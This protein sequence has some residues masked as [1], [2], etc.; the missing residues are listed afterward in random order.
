MFNNAE[1]REIPQA[2]S[3]EGPAECEQPQFAPL[4]GPAP[5]LD[6]QSEDSSPIIEPLAAP[7]DCNLELVCRA[8]ADAETGGPAGYAPFAA[9]KRRPPMPG[10]IDTHAVLVRAKREK[11]ESFKV[12]S[13]QMRGARQR[14]AAMPARPRRR[15]ANVASARADDDGDGGGGGDGDG[16]PAAARRALPRLSAE[17]LQE[18]FAYNPETG[19]LVW[20]VNIRQVRAGSIAGTDHSGGYL[21]VQLRGL[22][23]FVH[24]VCWAIAN[25]A[26]PIAEIDHIDGDRRNNKL[27]NLR[28]ATRAENGRNCKLN[29]N[30]RSGF[31]G[32]YWDKRNCKWRA[33]IGVNGKLLSLGHF[34]NI[35]NAVRAR[36]EATSRYFGE[37]ARET[38]AA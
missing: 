2:F 10:E 8:A 5:A 4:V 13:R 19:V 34:D 6:F 32:I 11:R 29:V 25:G 3:C 38:E 7:L 18:Y 14:A 35:A 9:P 15:R 16:E 17:E 27:G 12:C 33:L 22:R 1:I 20:R 31:K 21:S 28:E 23:Y 30:N 37:F 26:W 36:R 24:R